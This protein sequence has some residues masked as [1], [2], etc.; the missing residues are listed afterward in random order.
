L[1]LEIAPSA[2]RTVPLSFRRTLDAEESLSQ[3]NAASITYILA[4]LAIATFLTPRYGFNITLVTTWTMGTSINSA[5]HT[6]RVANL[7]I[8]TAF[9]DVVSGALRARSALNAQFDAGLALITFLAIGRAIDPILAV[10][11]GMSR[12]D[13]NRSHRY[14]ADDYDER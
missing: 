2:L 1:N 4:G 11:A 14:H 10:R 6:D 13:W 7:L 9:T 8:G 5:S 12:M 3:I